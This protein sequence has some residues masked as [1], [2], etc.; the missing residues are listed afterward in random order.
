MDKLVEKVYQHRNDYIIIGLTGKIGSGCT[1]A[2]DFLTKT[3]DDIVLPEINIGDT[4]RDDLRKKYIISRFYKKNWS[5]FTKIC[6]RDVITTFVLCNTFENLVAYI[7]KAI[8]DGIDIGFLKANYDEKMAYNDAF[9]AILEKR[10]NKQQ[11]TKEDAEFV[12]NYLTKVLPPFT[13]TIKKGLSAESYREFSKAF[14]L[15]GDNIRKSGCAIDET[16][17]P[18]NIY[19]L[20]ERINIITKIFRIYNGHVGKKNYYVIDAFRNPFEVHFF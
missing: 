5:Q 10:K 2:A 16:F 18:K 19:S 7:D 14:Q 1:T 13:I 20:A 6:V 11:V 9:V 8:P 4:S 3:A 15:F 12:F 17:D